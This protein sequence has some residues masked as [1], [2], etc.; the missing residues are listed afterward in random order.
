MFRKKSKIKTITVSMPKLLEIL[1]SGD[2]ITL[3]VMYKDNTYRL[4]RIGAYFC[5]KETFTTFDALKNYGHFG[6]RMLAMIND[7]VE[8]LSVNNKPPE[9]SELFAANSDKK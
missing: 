6:G 5:G 4:G 9:E 1:K 3:M 2:V 8:V 7:N